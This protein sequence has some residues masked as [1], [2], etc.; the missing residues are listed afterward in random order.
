MKVDIW[1]PIYIGD[2]LKDTQD[3]DDKEFGAYMR[4]LFYYWNLDGKMIND[5]DRI[6]KV[7]K[8]TA[9]EMDGIKYL[10][11]RYFKLSGN[12]YTH[13]RADEELDKA[14]NRRKSASENANKR[15]N[16][17]TESLPSDI[18]PDMPADILKGCSSSSP[19]SPSPSLPPTIKKEKK[20]KAE[21]QP[22]DTTLYNIIKTRFEKEQPQERF[23]NYGREGKAINGL[24]KKATD[25]T[26]EDP[27]TFLE[28]MI[29][30]F[31]HLRN[32]D[33]FFKGHPFLPSS[34]NSSGIWDRVL[35]AAADKWQEE[36]DAEENALEDIPF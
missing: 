6:R 16:K 19:S 4:I 15:W 29:R 5:I 8:Y 10:L 14:T 34:L 20:D 28:G 22:A 25:R 2:L 36:K 26:P 7:T 30:V 9:A 32:T 18:P 11:S 1:M 3:L 23:T 17:D 12:K 21:I 24:I 27:G 35:S 31:I 13:K 33:K